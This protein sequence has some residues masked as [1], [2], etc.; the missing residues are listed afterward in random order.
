MIATGDDGVANFMA[1]NNASACGISPS[2]PAT[3][4]YITAVGATQG[5][6]SGTP[7]ITCCSNTGGVITSGGGFSFYY[8]QP[9][10]QAAAVTNYLKT[11]PAGTLPPSSMF[12]AQ[13]RGYPDVAVMC[14]NYNV[15]IGGNTYQESGTSASTPVFAAIVTLING[16]RLAASKAPLGFLNPALYALAASTPS[17]FND[18]TVGRNN[19]C[20]QA[21]VC[22]QY[23]FNA[24]TGWDPLTGMGS[25]NFPTFSA[26]LAAL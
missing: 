23:A 11:A 4:P 15:V 1:R 21:A 13:G 2:W 22:C 19:C 16:Q 10:Y 18:I 5:P 20:A 7:E 12:N 9:S 8:P 26:A 24:T 6:E 17:A 25:V 14:Y 3:C